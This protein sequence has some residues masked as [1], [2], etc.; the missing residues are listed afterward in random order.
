MLFSKLTILQLIQFFLEKLI[1]CLIRPTVV[2]SVLKDHLKPTVKTSVCDTAS[3]KHLVKW[4]L[5][6]RSQT[7]GCEYNQ[8]DAVLFHSRTALL[9]DC[10]VAKTECLYCWTFY[11]L[12][13]SSFMG[14]SETLIPDFFYTVSQTL[15][16]IT[17]FQV[18]YATVE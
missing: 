17:K 15:Y 14:L 7:D 5:Q 10:A 4:R 1:Y 6:M 9:G 16:V 18:C 12:L 2:L 13:Y 3:F 8:F 11:T